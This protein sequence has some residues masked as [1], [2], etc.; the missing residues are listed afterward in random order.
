MSF[1]VDVEALLIGL[2]VMRLAGIPFE[3]KS[4]F[5]DCARAVANQSF[6]SGGPRLQDMPVISIRSHCASV[7]SEPCAIGAL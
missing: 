7:V 3:T 5:V 4:A 2:R 6:T 1:S